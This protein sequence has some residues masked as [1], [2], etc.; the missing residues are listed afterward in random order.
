MSSR[1]PWHASLPLEAEQE[2]QEKSNRLNVVGLL[3][4]TCTSLLAWQRHPQWEP[5]AN[6]P[7]TSLSSERG[8]PRGTSL[9][10]NSTTKGEGSLTIQQRE[11]SEEPSKGMRTA[12]KQGQKQNKKPF[13]I[14]LALLL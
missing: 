14:L 9:P 4:G 11:P 5:T 12:T 2:T 8:V 10:F 3:G 7:K 1:Q 6:P 13:P